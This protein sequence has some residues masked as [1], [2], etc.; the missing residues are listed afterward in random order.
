MKIEV[1]FPEFC[2]LFGDMG[3]IQYLKMCLPEATFIE[4]SIK[5]EPA[6]ISENVDMI[7]MAPM[8][9]RGQIKVIEKLKPYKE[10]I[11][12]LIENNTV[13]LFVGNALE[14]LGKYIEIEDGTKIEALGIFDV[15]AK[16]DINN[17]RSCLLLGNY[18]DIE[19]VGFK[20]Q[21]TTMYGDNSQDYFV[22]VQM[23]EGINENTNLE[24]I[25]KNHFIGTYIIGPIL[26]LNPLFT[27]KFLQ[28]LGVE[29]P[30]LAL[31]ED[32]KA[33]YSQ[34]LGEFKKIMST[35]I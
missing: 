5:D 6:F 25:Q 26:V 34:R 20:S 17:R 13:F 9:E 23:G 31:E 15:Y 8:T 22:Q 19:I 4:T 29:N 28:M 27:K 1:L 24:G 3:N 10:R 18:E 30:Q 7:Y 35:K 2:N 12:E 14:T 21:F 33:A 11:E 32:V 16:R